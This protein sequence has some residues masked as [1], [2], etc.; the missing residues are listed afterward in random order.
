MTTA[1]CECFS[2]MILCENA[3]KYPNESCSHVS[4]VAHLELHFPALFFGGLF[5][6]LLRCTSL[7]FS[8][9]GI[10]RLAL[11]DENY[12]FRVLFS[13]LIVSRMTYS[14]S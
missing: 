10:C 2:E 14:E 5:L 7:F 8:N 6:S 1:K 3:S 4:L 12:G 11:W 9:K 13:F